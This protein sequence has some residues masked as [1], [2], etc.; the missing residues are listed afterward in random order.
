[1]RTLIQNPKLKIWGDSMLEDSD[2][3]LIGSFQ[4]MIAGISKRLKK[5]KDD[6]W[7]IFEDGEF[8]YIFYQEFDPKKGV[9][10]DQSIVIDQN[11]R[12]KVFYKGK[13]LKIDSRIGRVSKG[14]P[15]IKKW[16]DL[17]TLIDSS[18]PKY[19]DKELCTNAADLLTL[20]QNSTPVIKQIIEI[21]YDEKRLLSK[22]P[23]SIKC[24]TSKNTNERKVK[25]VKSLENNLEISAKETES[26]VKIEHDYCDDIH[27][28]Y[29]T[30]NR[31]DY[32]IE[33]EVKI[34]K[35]DSE[36]E[37]NNDENVEELDLNQFD[38][39][40]EKRK[41]M[42]INPII[43]KC[44]I[45]QEEFSLIIH[46]TAHLK[47]NHNDVS[48]KCNL[49]DYKAQKKSG[50]NKHLM[51]HENPEL[52]THLCHICS[53]SFLSAGTL[54]V[55]IKLVH[56]NPNREKKLQCDQCEFVSNRIAHLRRHIRSV[57]LNKNQ[58]I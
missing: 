29:I 53:K 33:H 1:M 7:E 52:F 17:K 13:K 11:K 6:G 37:N 9:T 16:I 40:L 21:L 4:A 57:H 19:N 41:K 30:D 51:R 24:S 56:E 49:C 43:P 5:Y 26:I 35:I 42:Q 10:I 15:V 23:S 22:N 3:D 46:L 47:N 36:E 39:L 25:E 28:V 31:M 27:A 58:S 50:I 20:I 54:N 14:S 55:H 34:E 38:V 8:L 48:L 12:A 18:E 44:Y 32:E 2:E 45:C